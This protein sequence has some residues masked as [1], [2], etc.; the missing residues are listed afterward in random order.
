MSHIVQTT[1]KIKNPNMDLLRQ[2][3]ELVAQQ[4]EGGQVSA[5]YQ[6]YYSRVQQ[7]TTGI[8]VTTRVLRRGLGLNLDED[9]TLTF[10]GDPWAAEAEFDLL[11]QE[12]VQTFNSLAVIQVFT[13]MGY[14]SDVNQEQ[15]GSIAIRGVTYA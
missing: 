15:D 9:G 11:Q 5:T 10:I 13:A 6:D 1:T 2:A 14:S 8:A 7:P 12:I 4:H 3:V